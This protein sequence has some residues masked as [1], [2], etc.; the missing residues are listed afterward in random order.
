MFDGYMN[1]GS[2]SHHRLLVLKGP[3]FP[4][5]SADTSEHVCGRGCARSGGTRVGETH[6]HPW[7]HHCWVGGTERRSHKTL[8]TVQG[9]GGPEEVCRA[10]MWRGDTNPH[11]AGNNDN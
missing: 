7:R 1:G 10:Q 2:G 11:F 3:M 4:F 5:C 6:A 8:S 9:R